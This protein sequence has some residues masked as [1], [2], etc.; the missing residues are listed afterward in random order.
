MY[1]CDQDFLACLHPL[2][3]EFGLSQAQQPQVHKPIGQNGRHGFGHDALSPI[4][5]VEFIAGFGTMKAGIEVMQTTRTDDLVFVLEGD[6]PA[7][8]LAPGIACLG[9]FNGV[10]SFVYR[11]VRL[12]PVKLHGFLVRKEG[13]EHLCIPWLDWPELQAAGCERRKV[14][15]SGVNGH[16]GLLQERSFLALHR[17]TSALLWFSVAV[18]PWAGAGESG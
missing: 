1:F 18:Q 5:A 3:Q 14:S 9:L 10:T 16:P 7:N 4:H 12:M 15:E 6:A 17:I 2:L 11:P 13:K 8:G